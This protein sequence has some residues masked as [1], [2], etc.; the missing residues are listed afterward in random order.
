MCELLD[1]RWVEESGD[2]WMEGWVEGQMEKSVIVVLRD[3]W[4]YGWVDGLQ[5]NGWNDG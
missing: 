3:G 4:M 5:K 2:N 1:E